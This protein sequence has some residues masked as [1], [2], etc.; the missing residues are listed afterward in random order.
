MSLSRIAAKSASRVKCELA[1]DLSAIGFL[2]V[3][4]ELSIK[5]EGRGKRGGG[6]GEKERRGREGRG[7]EREKEKK[8]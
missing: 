5:K 3:P 6:R 4:V 1:S 7:K 2:T 8:A